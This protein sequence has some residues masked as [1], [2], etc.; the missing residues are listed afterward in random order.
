M[1]AWV[2]LLHY[3]NNRT[4]QIEMQNEDAVILAMK[5]LTNNPMGPITAV[6]INQFDGKIFYFRQG[7]QV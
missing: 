5:E 4:A 2:C 7:K 1:E 3:I 6:C